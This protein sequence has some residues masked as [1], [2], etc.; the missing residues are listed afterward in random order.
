M[1]FDFMNIY[2]EIYRKRDFQ[3]FINGVVSVFHRHLLFLEK[4]ML[5]V[6]SNIG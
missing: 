6:P 5:N 4:K 1:T 3:I 2:L